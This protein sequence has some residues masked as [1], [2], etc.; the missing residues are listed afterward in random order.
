MKRN[1]SIL[2]FIL[3]FIMLGALSGCGVKG[4]KELSEV[5][6]AYFPNI[7]H[8]QALLEKEDGS[9]QK[10]L[11]NKIKVNWQK[12]NA[13]SSEVEAFLAGEVD[14]GYIGPGPAINGYTKSKGEMQVI[15]GG[16]DA[17]AILVS[18]KDSNIKSVKD[19]SGKKVAI[20]Q[21]GNTQ[22][23]S[24]RI[25]LD[26]NGLKDKTKGGTVEIVQA[27]NPDIKTLLD[28][29][30]IDAAL[31]PEPWGSRLVKEVGAKV[32]LDYDKV[33]KNGKYPTAV[34]VARK[35]FIKNHSDIVEKFL[36]IHIQKTKSINENT[37]KTEDAINK[38]LK[39]ITGKTLDKD[40]LDSSFKRIKV[41]NNPEKEAISDMANWSLKEGF[42]KKKA[43]LK[44]MFDFNILNKILKSQGE[45]EIN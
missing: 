2:S 18:R 36:K 20:P 42:I 29:G 37:A 32:V 31:V 45:S 6:I 27:E 19:L 12:F 22:D 16:A 3:S 28:K 10:A 43:D 25:L 5:K 34:V 7:T 15:A 38:E 41:T 9:L 8:S 11:G 14:I 35:D 21:F 30:S 39:E 44:D 23:L 17:A 40:I 13:G 33:W 1:K 4:N 24:L 26:Q